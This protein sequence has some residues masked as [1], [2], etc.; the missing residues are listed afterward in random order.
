MKKD[1]KK[2]NKEINKIVNDI[3]KKYE[4]DFKIQVG[5]PKMNLKEGT[6]INVYKIVGLVE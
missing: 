6:S 4:I 3:S 1:I 2:A 5:E